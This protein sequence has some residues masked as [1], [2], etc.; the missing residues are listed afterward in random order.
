MRMNIDE[1]ATESDVFVGRGFKSI[2]GFN[3]FP[4]LL[5][6]K[7]ASFFQRIKSNLEVFN[8]KI[9]FRFLWC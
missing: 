7:T 3:F 8:F 4:R 6:F 5:S 2:I 9:L 1:Q